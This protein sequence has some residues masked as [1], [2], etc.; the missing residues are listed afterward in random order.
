M[1]PCPLCGDENCHC[2]QHAAEERAPLEFNPNFGQRKSWD[3][4]RLLMQYAIASR[5]WTLEA[6]AEKERRA[7][8]LRLERKKL[9]PET[10]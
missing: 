5:E 3:P 9:I 7:W 8:L 10:S 6:P 1:N 2:V 4:E